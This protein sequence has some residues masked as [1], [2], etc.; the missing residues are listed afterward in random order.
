MHIDVKHFQVPL[1]A[2]AR[3][4]AAQEGTRGAYRARGQGL[5]APYVKSAKHLK[6]NPGA[7]AVKVLAGVGHGKVL[8]WEYMDKKIWT[9]E[10]AAE[11]YS[12]HV[13]PALH[14]AFPGRRMWVVLEDN[15]PTGFKSS[16]GLRA[17]A[18]HKIKAF[19]LP[20]RS[21]ELNVCDFALWSEINRRMRRQERSWPRT[22]RET[23]KHFL[24]RLKRTALRLPATFVNKS[25]Q[26]MRRRCNRLFAAKGHHFEEGGRGAA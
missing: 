18:K 15:N 11:M 3:R 4:R 26:D 9:G 12:D 23:R 20:E 7:R 22:K 10:L 2:A 8:L 24:A 14:G 13:A 6:Y 1:H 25:V 19:Q 17:K 16:A 5:A 21:P